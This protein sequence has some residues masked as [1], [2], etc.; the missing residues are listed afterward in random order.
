[1]IL[2]D[3]LSK[4]SAPEIRLLKRVL[5]TIDIRYLYDALI[6]SEEQV[7]GRIS[8]IKDFLTQHIVEC[9]ISEVYDFRLFPIVTSPPPQLGRFG[10]SIR[11]GGTTSV[12]LGFG[13]PPA[14]MW[15][16]FQ[17][18]EH[19]F[20]RGGLHY[21]VKEWLVANQSEIGELKVGMFEHLQKLIPLL[22]LMDTAKEF[23]YIERIFG[24]HEYPL[25]RWSIDQFSGKAAFDDHMIRYIQHLNRMWP[26]TESAGSIPDAPLTL[27]QTIQ[28]KCPLVVEDPY[29]L[30]RETRWLND[31]YDV[32]D[33]EFDWP[34]GAINKLLVLPWSSF[35][36]QELCVRN[37]IR[38]VAASH[39]D[40]VCLFV[41]G[42]PKDRWQIV[43]L[44]PENTV[45]PGDAIEPSVLTQLHSP[46][47]LVN[48]HSGR[49]VV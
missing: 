44:C 16:E 42:M 47:A 39:R 17:L 29:R 25:F 36:A 12:F 22:K 24:P 6:E 2:R 4:E 21:I 43:M 27:V 41:N 18:N 1:M 37:N 32:V 15:E 33:A 3:Q 23:R 9:K 26:P 38:H 10:A 5:G 11:K 49:R 14:D 20:A 19:Y 48:I 8:L 28:S 13:S 45:N 35:E 7:K 30:L 34:D 46:L 40:T 31:F